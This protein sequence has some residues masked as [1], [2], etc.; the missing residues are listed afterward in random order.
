MLR[1]TKVPQQGS[2]FRVQCSGSTGN[3]EN[4]ANVTL[5]GD[6]IEKVKKLSYLGDVL[7]F[8]GGVQKAV[9]AGTRSGWEKLNNTASALYK[10]VASLILRR[11][12]YKSCVRSALCYGTECWALNKKDIRKLQT[13]E[14]RMLR[15]IYKKTLKDGISNKA[16]R[17][18]TGVEK[19]EEFLKE[20]RLQW[21]GMWI[22]WK[23]KVLQ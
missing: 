17:N 16:I 13:T 23:R 4:D 3:A 10:K 9:T 2:G 21:L 1:N 5:D 8:D 20:Q 11:S 12:L 14:M 22:R 15:L 6:V 18:M 7:S 19:I